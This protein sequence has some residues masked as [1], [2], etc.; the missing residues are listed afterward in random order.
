VK[1]LRTILTTTIVIVSFTFITGNVYGTTYY[2]AKNGNN[3]NSGTEAQP[4]LTIQKAANT[5]VVGDTVYIKEG[6]Y[7]EIVSPQNSGSS[8]SYITYS[9]YSGDTVTIDGNNITLPSYESGLFEVEN[10]SYIK[11]SELRIINAGPNDNN[12][13]IYVDNSSHV[14]IENNYTYNTVS[15]GIGVWNSNNITIDG[16]EVQLACNDGEQESITVA[17]TD[18]F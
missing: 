9:A 11:I 8:Q 14:I 15:S 13:G 18:T 7:N 12:A 16:N 17:G 6:T 2:V 10:K 5:I 4:W 1:Y 3:S